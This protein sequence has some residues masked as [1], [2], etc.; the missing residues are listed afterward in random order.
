V[1][2]QVHTCARAHVRTCTRARVHV[3]TCSLSTHA[4]R[5]VKHTGH[6]HSRAPSHVLIIRIQIRIQDIAR[7]CLHA[8]MR[9]RIIVGVVW[10][11]VYACMHKCECR[12]CTRASMHMCTR[13]STHMCTR[14][15]THICTRTTVALLG[16]DD[17][18]GDDVEGCGQESRCPS[19]KSPENRLR[20]FC[21]LLSVNKCVCV[22]ARARAR[23][24]VRAC[25]HA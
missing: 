2:T 11:S 6:A 13:A 7:P 20:L 18:G 12:C 22:C 24:C 9:T 23:S 14:A 5:T 21:E 3:K 1:Y 10:C 25:M 19:S 15:S 4:R 16:G 17:A 8:C